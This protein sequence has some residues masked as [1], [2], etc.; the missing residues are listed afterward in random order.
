M[1]PYSPYR[2]ALPSLLSF[3]LSLSSTPSLTPYSISLSHTH[4]STLHT[5][6]YMGC[7]VKADVKKKDSK[8]KS[9]F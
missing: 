8:F 3:P 4:C 2:L 5:Q 6:Q 7:T 1:A 9:F